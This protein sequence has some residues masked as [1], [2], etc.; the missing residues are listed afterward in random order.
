M[1]ARRSAIGAKVR[2]G[3]GVALVAALLAVAAASLD[4]LDTWEARTWDWRA[5]AL[6]RPGA[7]TDQIRLIL[8]D[9][10]SLDWAKTENGLGWPWPREM[11]AAIIDY[12]RRNGARAVALDILF[13]EPSAYG[14]GDDHVLRNAMAGG[15]EVIAALFL[16]RQ[17][18][19]AD[20]W[21]DGGDRAGV[22]VD[23]LG[24]WQAVRGEDTLVYPRAALPVPELRRAAA[25]LGN[26]Q[27][28]P[29]PDGV[30][31]RTPLFGAFDGRVFP[32][33]GIAPRLLEKRAAMRIHGGRLV[34]GDKSI[35]I[36]RQGR[37]ILKFRGPAGTMQSFSAAA[38]L[39]SEIRYRMGQPPT[40]TDP[41]AV[42]GKYVFVGFSAPGLFDLRSAPVDGVFTGVEIHATMLDNLLS[43][44]FVRSVPAWLTAAFILS[45]ALFVGTAESLSRKP[46]STMSIS[47]AGLALPVICSLQAY[48]SGFWLPLVSAELA[49]VLSI[50]LAL[51]VKY[52]TE[53]RQKRFIKNAFRQYLSP[54]V[55]DQI[56]ENPERLKLGGERKTI[57]IFFSD[58][59][60][61]TTISEGLDPEQLTALLNEYLSAM[62]DIVREEGGTVD[63]YEGDAIIA[64]W[65][66]PLDV[67]EHA[68][69][70]V[71]A[72][73]RCQAKLASMRPEFLKRIGKELHMRIG[74]NTGDAVVGNMGSTS[75]F[76]YTM[77]GDAVNLA[78]R[79][80]GANKQ[81]GTYTMISE[82]TRRML[83][84]EFAFRE[85]ARLAV[86]GRKE[87]VVVYE[88]M[89][90]ASAD[91]L[92]DCHRVFQQGL[93]RFYTGDFSGAAN[94]FLTI[95][96]TDPAAAA[97]MEKCSSLMEAPPSGSWE[98]V[99]VA[100][101]K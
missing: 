55:I 22:Q 58:L 78:A 74:I 45:L 46:L 69:C 94:R 31:R 93:E 2:R 5:R 64:F 90:P 100:T 65:N 12:C 52:A 30:Y 32:S 47:A 13:T 75:R 54:A 72:A 36:D 4:W 101:S 18:G 41:N 24:K 51:A 62:T 10:N 61:F 25:L 77:L 63:K 40:I 21:P 8:V 27:M 66:A 57:S 81:F 38:V 42:R 14:V 87:P 71:R 56:L 97:Y 7:A 35:P 73:L 1:S 39:Q 3:I 49:V 91:D 98:G 95:A 59:Q 11:Y 80:E 15:R 16:G 67:P 20:A 86:V 48:R 44:D 92:S 83:G 26:V 99:W 29:D 43:G 76:D 17:S 96:A 9:Q 88:P 19:D 53:G 28:H 34:V 70:C 23:G 50:T 6:A 33:L 82:Y 85:L 89:P 68:A 37:A 84:D 79:L 60:G